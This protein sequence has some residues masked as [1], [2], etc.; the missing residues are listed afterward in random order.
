MKRMILLCAAAMVTAS[1]D[2]RAHNEADWQRHDSW[3]FCNA[4]I[5]EYPK[6]PA[7]SCGALQMCANEGALSDAET[8][9]LNEMI[10]HAKDCPTP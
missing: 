7:P 8:K 2:Q 1:C 9:K 6:S 10:A 5:A 3:R 4:A